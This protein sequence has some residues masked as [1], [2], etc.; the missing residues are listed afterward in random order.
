MPEVVRS[1]IEERDFDQIRILQKRIL[2]A[3]EQDFSKH[4]PYDLV[5]KIRMCG[6]AFLPNWQKKQKSY[7]DLSEKVRERRSTKR[8]L[9]G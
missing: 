3:Y 4:A 9:C 1:Y 5:P 7:T 8:R 6:T 2:A